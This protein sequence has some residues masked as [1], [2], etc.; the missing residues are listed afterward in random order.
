LV[1]HYKYRFSFCGIHAEKCRGSNALYRHYG[2]IYG[3]LK[4]SLGS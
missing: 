3:R 2:E 4:Q 1:M